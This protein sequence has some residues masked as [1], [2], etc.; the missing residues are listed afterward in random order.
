[1]YPFIIEQV[2]PCAACALIGESVSGQEQIGVIA[3]L[4]RGEVNGFCQIHGAENR[5]QL[6]GV[7]TRVLFED[8]DFGMIVERESFLCGLVIDDN[9]AESSDPF[10]KQRQDR[11][12][13]DPDNR[14]VLHRDNTG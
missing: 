13:D 1:M 10:Q 6:V 12:Q 5:T 3:E 14:P 2:R 4:T 8:Q 7:I 11:N 9:G